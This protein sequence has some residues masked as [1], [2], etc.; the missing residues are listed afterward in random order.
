MLSQIIYLKG[1]FHSHSCYRKQPS[2]SPFQPSSSSSFVLGFV[3]VAKWSI[4][5]W[6]PTSTQGMCF[7]SFLI[8]VRF[9]K[10]FSPD[11]FVSTSPFVGGTMIGIQPRFHK[12][13]SVE[14]TWP[15]SLSL[16][17]NLALGGHSQKVSVHF[18]FGCMFFFIVYAFFCVL[19]LKE[20]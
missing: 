8:F 6:S 3:T 19:L 13:F 11:C 14:C 4:L 9:C 20:T 2:S 1:F 17:T 5:R 15:V 12:P 16:T 10:P 18:G 7:A